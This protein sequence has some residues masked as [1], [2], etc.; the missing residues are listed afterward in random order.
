METAGVSPSRIKYGRL[1]WMGLGEAAEKAA[2]AKMN[3]RIRMRCR[4]AAGSRCQ[5]HSFQIDFGHSGPGPECPLFCPLPRHRTEHCFTLQM[6]RAI[7]TRPLSRIFRTGLCT[8]APLSFPEG[9][10]LLPTSQ[11]PISPKPHFF[12][13]V[14]TDGKQLPTYRVIDGVGNVIEG[15]ELPEA[16]PN[17]CALLSRVLIVM[18]A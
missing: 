12:N 8:T 2:A 15:A 4:T 13:S 1:S 3:R 9:H 7:R 6:I 18:P 10:G 5:S 17:L 14:S 16:C 11:S